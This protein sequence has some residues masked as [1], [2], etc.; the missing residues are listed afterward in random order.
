MRAEFVKA[1][2]EV[3]KREDVIFMTGDLGFMALE[4]LRDLMGKRFINAGVAEQ[5]MVTTAA[6]LSSQGFTVFCYSIAPFLVL[7]ALEQIRNDVCLHNMNV[8][9]VG[10]GGG[11]GYGIMGAT[12]HMLEDFACMGVMPNMR[13]LVP[14][15][16]D[17][18]GQCITNMTLVP[19][20]AYL[21]LG[22]AAY[23]ASPF[24][25]WRKLRPATISEPTLV[26][27]IGQVLESFVA[28]YYSVWAVSELPLLGVPPAEFL[29]EL[30]R[31]NK[32]IVVEEHYAKGGLGAAL[33]LKLATMGIPIPKLE[34]RYAKGY[35]SGTYGSQAFHRKESGLTG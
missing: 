9:L 35:P 30:S 22:K 17:D 27:G 10:N 32:L 25:P 4:P 29:D 2:L 6:G 1:M 20:P 26:V 21:R 15:S 23:G 31:V 7:R 14:Y 19:G 33:A 3:G 12:H 28:G 8:K 5:N 18:V 13:V 16:S 24:A 34:H 11:Y